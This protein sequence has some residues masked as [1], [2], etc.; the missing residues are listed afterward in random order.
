MTWSPIIWG[1]GLPSGR[2][3]SPTPRPVVSHT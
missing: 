3:G 1:H 2:P